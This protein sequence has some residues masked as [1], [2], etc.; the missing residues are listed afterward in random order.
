MPRISNIT[1]DNTVE[2]NDRLL[3]SNSG[4]ATKNFSVQDIST[5]LKETN[6]AGNPTQLTY[7]YDSSLSTGNISA[8]SVTNFET[9]STR[10]ITFSIYTHGNITD[11]RADFIDALSSQQVILI[12]VANPNN[13]MV[14][15]VSNVTN[16]VG[17]ISKTLTFG[18]PS[19]GKG[20][21]ISG[22]VYSLSLYPGGGGISIISSSTLSKTISIQPVD[23]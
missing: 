22:Q 9:S 23:L 4:G 15:T 21:I 13:F 3:G 19:S 6:A 12:N 1:S 10:T 5:F 2:S 11:T 8:P 14:A 20:S 7:K 18:A 16:V 17:A